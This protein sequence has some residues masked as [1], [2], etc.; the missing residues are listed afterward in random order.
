M[1]ARAAREEGKGDG[2]EDARKVKEGEEGDDEGGDDEKDELLLLDDD[3]DN[4]EDIC[5]TSWLASR[6]VPGLWPA[7]DSSQT[8]PWG[9]APPVPGSRA[10][11]SWREE[12]LEID[13]ERVTDFYQRMIQ[14]IRSHECSG[15]ESPTR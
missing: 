13:D 9:A 2:E 7:P 3:D 6:G 11:V 4:E 12:C 5:A 15:S 8:V 1:A 14:K 10:T